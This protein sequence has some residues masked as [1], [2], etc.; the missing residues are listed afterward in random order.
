VVSARVPRLPTDQTSS[1]YETELADPVAVLLP[2]IH[3]VQ[4]TG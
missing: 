2:L 3:A 1:L 4:G